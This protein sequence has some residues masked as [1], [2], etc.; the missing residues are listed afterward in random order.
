M[1]DGLLRT[2][3]EAE[4]EVTVWLAQDTSKRKDPNKWSVAHVYYTPKVEANNVTWK[5]IW[6]EVVASSLGEHKFT[7]RLNLEGDLSYNS[8][9]TT[10]TQAVRVSYSYAQYKPD[11]CPENVGYTDVD[12]LVF[13]VLLIKPTTAPT[14]DLRLPSSS[15]HQQTFRG[16][17]VVLLILAWL[18]IAMQ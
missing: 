12:D 9:S 10:V 2:G 14:K 7:T 5:Y 4:L 6:S 1:D 17:S 16:A 18:T 8:S 13:D 3:K 15:G 11:Q